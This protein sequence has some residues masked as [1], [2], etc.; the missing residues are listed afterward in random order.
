MAVIVWDIALL[1]RSLTFDYLEFHDILLLS[2][3]ESISL[4]ILESG[5]RRP[6][7]SVLY[8]DDSLCSE[9]DISEFLTVVFYNRL[10]NQNCF[11]DDFSEFSTL[12]SL[13]GVIYCKPFLL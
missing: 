3:I 1:N 13:C 10:F 7:F 12:T 8:I 2:L 9:F 5:D 4:S 11:Q 6:S